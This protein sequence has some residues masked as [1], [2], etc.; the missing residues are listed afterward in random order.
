MATLTVEQA[1]RYVREALNRLHDPAYLRKSPL[2]A[3]FGVADR[4]DTP[5]A[6]RTV[7][8]EGIECLEPKPDAPADSRAWRMYE[9][10]F[11]R[12]V[13]ESPQEDV[14]EQL[15]LSLR[16]LR[17]EQ[18]AALEALTYHFWEQHGLG[19][20]SVGPAD[21]PATP[22]QASPALNEE[23]AWLKNA[24]PESSTDPAE[25]LPAAAALVEPLATRHGVRLEIAMAA[26]LPRLPVDPV[27]L[28]Q[29]LLHLLSVAIPQTG[30]GGQVH[31]SAR[32]QA[33]EVEIQVR[34]AGPGGAATAPSDAS[35]LD[36]AGRLAALCG[37]RL[38]LA[39]GERPFAAT[40][41]CPA[42]EQLPILAIDDNAG[43][44][45]L[46]QRYAAGT[47]YRLIGTQD[48]QEVL[49]LAEATSPQVIVLDVMM[50]RVDGWEVLG[51]LRQHPLTAH[52]PII[53]CTI[54]TQEELALSLG[55]SDFLPKPVTRQAFLA[56]LDRQLAPARESH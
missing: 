30:P 13:H 16:Q 33:W 2:A 52:L 39:S 29:I 35:S 50:P 12:Y 49:A 26:P 51:R 23:L 3:L 11:Y 45:H 46:L 40:L 10:L 15:G 1:L 24:P 20:N 53:V 7:L 21:E 19:G 43:T 6:L 56:A 9:S 47:R 32:P 5:A 42:L 37:G 14:A 18:R 22:A 48:P 54:L 38:A 4:F 25:V 31:I 55:A 17:R 41:T 44:L 34:S 8:I 27:G 36:M 28:R